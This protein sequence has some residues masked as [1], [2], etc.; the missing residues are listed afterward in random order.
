MENEVDQLVK[1]LKNNKKLV[2]M[3][4]PSFVAEF[5]YPEIVVYLKKIGFD[6]VVELTFGAKVVNHEYHKILECSKNNCFW[7]SS[8]CPGIVITIKQKYPNL[9][10]NLIPIVSPMVATARLCKKLY[11]K[12]KI[13]FISPCNMKKIEAKNNKDC[14]DYAIDYQQLR[15]LF[16]QFKINSDKKLKGKHVHFDKF[17]NDYTKIYPLAGGLSK[18]AHLKGIVNP[19]NT[20]IIDGILDVEKFLNNIDK[21]IRFL[22]VNFCK[23]GCIGGPCLSK[24][25]FLDAKKKKVLKYVK[26]AMNETI[27][28]ADKGILKRAQGMNLKI[29]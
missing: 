22:D 8:V 2:V 16:N 21:K 4:A 7:I 24:K 9:V 5:N 10:K 3:L 18:T 14:V 28:E 1:E 26:Y 13:V 20:K 12:H 29:K 15:N 23:G 27:P 17:Y 25:L 11:P 6:K 19:N